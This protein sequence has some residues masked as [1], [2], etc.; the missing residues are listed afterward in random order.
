MGTSFSGVITKQEIEAKSQEF[1]I[2]ISNV[3]RDYVFGWILAGIYSGNPLGN[4]LVLKGGNCFRKAYFANTRFSNDLDFS[5]PSALD[6]AFLATQLNAICDFVQDKAG[7][8]F[9]KNRNKV[10]EKSNFRQ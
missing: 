2:H 8:V 7:V 1:D 5:T 9:E 3:E 10:E 6:S 4:F